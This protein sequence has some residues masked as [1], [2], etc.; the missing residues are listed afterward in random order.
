L[1][2]DTGPFKSNLVRQ[3]LALTINRPQLVNSLF[4]GYADIGNDSPFAPVFPASVGAPAVPQRVQNIKMAKELLK[5]AGYARGFSTP[6]LTEQ[7]QEM[8]ELAQ[9][10]KTWAKEIGV[11]INLT[12]EQPN[13]YYGSGVYGTS[14]WLDGEMSMVDYGARSTPNLFL[15][16]PLMTYDKATGTGAWNAAR[17]NNAAYDKLAQEYVAATDISSQRSAAKQIETLLLEQTPI[18]Y[19]YFYNYLSATQKNVKGVYPT[20]LSQFFL[21]NASKS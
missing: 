15:N 8:P 20:A 6:L 13:K 1:R 7:R 17:F 21:W 9:F 2:C 19:P 11:D 4:R 3:A 5:R 12:I 14:D 18:I 10:I 16:A